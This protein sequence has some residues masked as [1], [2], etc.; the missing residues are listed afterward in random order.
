MNK[1]KVGDLVKKDN[2][3]YFVKSFIYDD[4]YNCYLYSIWHNTEMWSYV[5][6]QELELVSTSEEL[7]VEKFKEEIK[8]KIIKQI[9]NLDFLR[10]ND[11]KSKELEEYVLKNDVVKLILFELL[12]KD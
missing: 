12:E 11:Q 8:D 6:E 3:N 9:N 2:S 4:F 7:A 10:A 5:A 1:F